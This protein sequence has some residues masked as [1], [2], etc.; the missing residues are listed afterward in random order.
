M[1]QAGVRRKTCFS[2][3]SGPVSCFGKGNYPS[4]NACKITVYFIFLKKLQ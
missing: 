4:C 1:G 2:Q 3:K